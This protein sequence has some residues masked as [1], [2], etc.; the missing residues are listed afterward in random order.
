MN[1]HSPWGLFHS[2]TIIE[3]ELGPAKPRLVY[4]T[5]II[6]LDKVYVNVI[7]DVLL[8]IF[9]IVHFNWIANIYRVETPQARK[10]AKFHQPFAC[11]S[12]PH[13]CHHYKYLPPLLFPDWF[14]SILS[15]P[16]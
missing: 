1:V 10:G 4:V 7:P 8:R 11:H 5:F 12:L 15:G 2:Q 13:Q 6:F 14:R 3:I 16:R 9:C